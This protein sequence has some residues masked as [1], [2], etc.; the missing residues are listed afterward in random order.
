[1][2]IFVYKELTDFALRKYTNISS[3]LHYDILGLKNSKKVIDID[4]IRLIHDSFFLHETPVTLS[5]QPFL[6][7]RRPGRTQNNFFGGR[8]WIISSISVTW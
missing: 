6:G 3:S 7:D 2:P 4:G 5:R 1:M 8:V